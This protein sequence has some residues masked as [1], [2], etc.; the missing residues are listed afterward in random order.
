MNVAEIS[1]I[2]SIF[3]H[4]VH[5]S[6]HIHWHNAWVRTHIVNECTYYVFLQKF[7]NLFQI[8]HFFFLIFITTYN[9]SQKWW[10]ELCNSLRGILQ[11]FV[12]LFLISL[13]LV[14]WFIINN[15]FFFILFFNNIFLNNLT[16]YNNGLF[17]IVLFNFILIL[18]I[19]YLWLFLFLKF[20]FFFLQLHLILIHVL[21]VLKIKKTFY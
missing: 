16:S 5:Q 12:L 9:L 17:F 18:N 4:W 19:F 8:I 10:I 15:V 11:H 13:L 6:F 21:D 3:V 2:D 20:R 14:N 1:Q 7:G